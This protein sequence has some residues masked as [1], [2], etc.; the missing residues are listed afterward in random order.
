MPDSPLEIAVPQER[1][2][3]LALEAHARKS[4]ARITNNAAET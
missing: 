1:L 3:L 2:Y 4:A